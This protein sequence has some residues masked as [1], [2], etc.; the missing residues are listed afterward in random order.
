VKAQGDLC[1]SY[2]NVFIIKKH[3]FDLY[4]SSG[5]NSRPGRPQLPHLPNLLGRQVHRQVLIPAAACAS[6]TLTPPHNLPSGVY[7][8]R[9]RQ[10]NSVWQVPVVRQ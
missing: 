7:L 1:F 6:A 8:L 2:C 3:F 5:F 9:V 10:G 4:F